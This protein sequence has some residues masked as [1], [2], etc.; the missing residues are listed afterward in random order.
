MNIPGRIPE[1]NPILRSLAKYG[2]IPYRHQKQRGEIFSMSFDRTF[3]NSYKELKIYAQSSAWY[4]GSMEAHTQAP[5]NTNHLI[6]VRNQKTIY[7]IPKINDRMDRLN[8]EKNKKIQKSRPIGPIQLFN[9]ILKTWRLD[10]SDT[11]ALLGL[12]PSDQD[13]AHD[14][15][16]GRKPVKGRDVKDRLAYLIQIRMTL[17]GWFRDEAVESEWLREPQKLLDG[18][19]PMDLLLEGSMENLLLVKEYV[20]AAT[21]W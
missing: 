20:Q 19:A 8:T 16:I 14:L 18:K 9:T 3:S 17:S 13:Y 6:S 12:D 11:I 7:I 2:K 21:G 10:E 1:G 4:L 5:R 15:L